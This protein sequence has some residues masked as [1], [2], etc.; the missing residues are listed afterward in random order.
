M[1]I[2]FFRNVQSFDQLRHKTDAFRGIVAECQIITTIELEDKDYKA[3]CSD[4]MR[5]YSFLSPYI[6]KSKIINDVWYGILVKCG[7]Q[8][9]VVVMNGYQYPRYVGLIQQNSG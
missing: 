5:D 1:E 9:V 6:I 8:S 7:G 3:F 4:F 2:S